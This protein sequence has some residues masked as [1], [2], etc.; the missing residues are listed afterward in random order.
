[1]LMMV[2]DF[3]LNHDRRYKAGRPDDVHEV[4]VHAAV[5]LLVG[6]LEDLIAWAMACAVDE[7]VN[8]TPGLHSLVN[9]PLQVR[10][11]LIGA[12]YANPC[13]FFCERLAFAGRRKNGDF[14]A[15]M[16]KPA[17]R[18]CPHTLTSPTAN[19]PRLR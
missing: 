17:G 8:P 11:R 19:R 5:P 9:Q 4:N 1:M 13:E 6:D 2:P 14:E 3:L 7:H 18:C 16:S 10:A 15:I 12:G